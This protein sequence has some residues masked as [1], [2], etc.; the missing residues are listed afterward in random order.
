MRSILGA[1]LLVGVVANTAEAQDNFGSGT[2]PLLKLLSGS[3]RALGMANAVP[4]SAIDSD[5]IF[6]H[7]ALLPNAAGMSG[8]VQ[9]FGGD[10]TLAT[11][12]AAATG[13]IGI[14]IRFLEYTAPGLGSDDLGTVTDLGRDD[15]AGNQAIEA[16]ARV[17]YA[18]TVKKLRLGAGVEYARHYQGE[19]SDGM[20]TGDVGITVN[21]TNRFITALAVRD[22]PFQ[23]GSDAFDS[24]F[25][26]VLGASNRSLP[27]GPLDVIASGSIAWG[28]DLDVFGGAGLE[29][30]YW[31][32]SGLNFY[33]RGGLRGGS[34]GRVTSGAGISYQRFSLDYAFEQF[35][36]VAD[37]HRI[38]LRL[39]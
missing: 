35:N 4:L 18:R 26:V 24:P 23:N 29:L 22:I 21:P 5:I 28:P 37:A 30:G 1:M 2:G 25:H 17:G 31:P 11:F 39:R 33:A 15:L 6:Y 36:N 19:S 27:F 38:G 34:Y 20:F 10:A 16:A 7:P 9:R 13:G 8:A 14:G 32:F 12:S 3:T